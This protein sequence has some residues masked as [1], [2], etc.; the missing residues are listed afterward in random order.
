MTIKKS[1]VPEG[2]TANGIAE[3]SV[4]L[5]LLHMSPEDREAYK[6]YQENKSS[7]DCAIQ[8]ALMDGET[9]A[10]QEIAKN[11]KTIGISTNDIIKATGLAVDD[12]LRL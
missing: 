8:T 2:Y 3:A 10:R 4:K 7:V 12:V 5:D 11:L 1:T 6:K 9:K